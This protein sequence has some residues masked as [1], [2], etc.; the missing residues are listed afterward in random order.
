MTMPQNSCGTPQNIYGPFQQTLFMG[1]SVMSFSAHM[2]WNQEVSEVTVQLIQDPC[3]APAGGYKI[4]YDNNLEQQ[5][6][7]AADPGMAIFDGSAYPIM[8]TP[9]YFRVAD[10]EFSGILQSWV[11]SD[12]PDGHPVYTVKLSDPRAILEGTQLIID[13]YALGTYSN[14]NILN[15]YGLH[16]TLA[17]NCSA[18]SGYGINGYGGARVNHNGMPWNKIKSAISFLT[19]SLPAY[20]SNYCYTGRLVYRGST[21]AYGMG[22]LP[23]NGDGTASYLVDLSGVPYAPTYYRV[24]GT[25]VGLLD[26]ISTLCA[27]AG[28]DFYVELLPTLIG[29]SIYNIITIRT[30]SRATQPSL[31]AINTLL[32]ASTNIINST[33]GVELRNENMG[34]FVIGGPKQR[35]YAI[36]QNDNGTTDDLSD[37]A[38]CPFFGINQSTGYA[39][40][41]S[42]TSDTNE[43]YFNTDLTTLNT[44]LITALAITDANIYENEMRAAMQGMD[45]WLS[46]SSMMGTRPTV[47]KG[48]TDAHGKQGAKGVHDFSFIINAITAA[49]TNNAI[50][51]HQA[52][53]AGAVFRQDQADLQKDMQTA[54]DFVRTFATEY[55][56]RKYAVRISDICWKTD[57]ESNYPLTSEEVS[58]GGWVAGGSTIIGLP[59]ITDLSDFFAL[60]DGRLQAFVRY[61]DV[62]GNDYDLSSV[63][64]DDCGIYAGDAYI[65]VQ[66]DSKLVYMA[67][68]VGG[69]I[70]PR[71]VITL[72]QMMCK[73]Y[74]GDAANIGFLGMKAGIDIVD[75]INVTFNKLKTIKATVGSKVMQWH[76]HYVART[77][78]AATIPFKSNVLTYGP[79]PNTAAYYPPGKVNIIFDEGLVPWEYGDQTTLDLAGFER[80]LE[81]VTQ[82]YAGEMGSMTIPGYPTLPLGAEISSTGTTFLF[83]NRIAVSGASGTTLTPETWYG[84]M[85]PNIT[86]IN[87]EVGPGGV[88]TSYTMRTFTPQFGKF[89]KANVE[90]LRSNG[91]RNAEQAKLFRKFSSIRANLDARV[92]ATANKNA[93]GARKGSASDPIANTPHIMLVGQMVNY[94]DAEY[95]QTAVSTESIF[96]ANWTFAEDYV[97]KA[98][99]SL[100]GILRPVS[101]S[102]DGGLP[103]FAASLSGCQITNS[104]GA[105]PPMR[106]ISN[107]TSLYGVDIRSKYLNPLLGP[108]GDKHGSGT[109]HDIDILAYGTGS[110]TGSLSMHMQGYSNAERKEYAADYRF[111]AHRGPMVLTG[112]GYDLDGKPIPNAADTE[113]NATDGT[114]TES[115][116]KDTFMDNWLRK[117]HT[118]PVGPIDLRFDRRRGVWVSPPAYRLVCGQLCE[119][120]PANGTGD[121]MMISGETLYDSAGSTVPYGTKSTAPHFTLKD[122]IGLALGSGAKF[123]AYYDP[124]ACE[125][126]AIA[127]PNKTIQV[128]VSGGCSGGMVALYRSGILVPDYG[129]PQ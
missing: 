6:W 129:A 89:G 54:Y 109:G 71:A 50:L 20:S 64:M 29:G 74:T 111:L 55:Y 9:L 1:C 88:Q 56:G 14:Y 121:A 105:Q 35:M 80:S 22:C 123:I 26:V 122:R 99:M 32:S 63:S 17:A 91:R 76:M 44:Q 104:A 5:Q 52:V 15:V 53:P 12:G 33:H 124:A 66:V 126:Y 7:T 128:V 114:F 106:K 127:H 69:D 60:E 8:G 36:E 47:W 70:V 116:L 45:E 2:G 31:G 4:Y 98:A 107:P 102:G 37:D 119:A 28:S 117:P 112:W 40:A 68:G 57:E 101:V 67:Y 25:N 86:N 78:D 19:A 30:V 85:G 51:A 49:D 77:P 3:P 23:S 110:H 120:M 16:E 92:Q 90:R 115:A 39:I 83:E 95:R 34:N 87:T 79:W 97:N 27:D 84:S 100:D 48:F 13:K 82:M 42:V 96:D 38:I 18:Y 93:N 41:S 94:K 21:C 118:W 46:Y 72:P 58:D 24:S 81:S 62:A 108:G 125:Y 59:V 113:G 73:K 61:D 65:K 75:D 43:I 11:A 10:F 103:R